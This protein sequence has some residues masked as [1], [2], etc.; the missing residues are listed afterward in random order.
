MRTT[1]Q[2]CHAMFMARRAR[3]LNQTQ[4]AEHVASLTSRNLSQAEISQIESGRRDRH[5]AVAVIS[6][7]LEIPSPEEKTTSRVKREDYGAMIE[8]SLTDDELERLDLHAV[9]N[10]LVNTD[11]VPDRAA[12]LRLIIGQLM[13]P[14][15]LPSF[16]ATNDDAPAS[17]RVGIHLLCRDDLGVT[18]HEDGSFET[19]AWR[20]NERWLR[21]PDYVA[22][23]QRKRDESYRQGQLL[24]YWPDDERPDRFVLLVRPDRGSVSW[25]GL[26][27]GQNPIGIKRL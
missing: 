16:E 4:L 12:A 21:S 23:H 15:D 7:V 19:R 22:L 3:D 6:H 11:G 27:E 8:L 2:W 24:D 9:Q 10:V 14:S 17:Q 26:Q 1:P 25:P 18:E 13:H 20:I 5:W